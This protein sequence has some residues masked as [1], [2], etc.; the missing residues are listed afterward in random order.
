MY[1]DLLKKMNK[2]ALYIYISYKK[3]KLEMKSLVYLIKKLSHEKF[4]IKPV[5]II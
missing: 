1:K 4:R 5:I 3:V 2:H